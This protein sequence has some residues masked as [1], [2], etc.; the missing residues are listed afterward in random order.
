[1][2]YAATPL[3]VRLARKSVVDPATGC[4]LWTD[5]PDRDGYGRL[6]VA[7]KARKAH[8]VAYEV[9]VGPVPGDLCVCHKCD[10]RLCV[11]PE[12]LFLGTNTENVADMVRK[13]RAPHVKNPMPGERN[14]RAVLTLAQ[15]QAAR[16]L[17]LNRG[18]TRAS[19]ARRFG[20]G[21][22]AIC[23]IVNGQAWAESALIARCAN[24]GR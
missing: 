13:G 8:R 19:A 3:D 5:A 1:M 6:Q 14:G 12:H 9:H 11:N 20:V 10:V 24:T 2:G 15:A 7:G 23:R 4:W 21:E 18:H 16:D 17:V 22:T